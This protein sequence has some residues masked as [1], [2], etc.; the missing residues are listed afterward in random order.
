V[1]PVSPVLLLLAAGSSSRMRGGDKLLEDVGGEPML[2]RAAR[3][4][5]GTGLQVIVALRP[6]RPDR[7]RVLEGLPVTP[8]LVPDPGDGMSAS[9][10]AAASVAPQDA[11]LAVCLADMPEITTED[12]AA[13]VEAYHAAGGDR[14]VRA[15]SEDGRPGQPV[16][17]PPR[18]R[19]DLLA[20]SGDAGGRDILRTETPILVP[21]RGLRALTDL[22][23]PEDFA[24]WR[25]GRR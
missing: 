8:V 17:F 4:A 3:M 14:V 2:T 10:R 5:A 7:A 21:L 19:D 6:D 20:L 9:L 1:G 22:D 16:I 12:L 18:L 11:P 13:L 15:A 25:G 24:A 23:T